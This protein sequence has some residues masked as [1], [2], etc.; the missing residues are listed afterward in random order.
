[1]LF[2][3]MCAPLLLL[4]ALLGVSTACP[5]VLEPPYLIREVG[6]KISVNCTT[7]LHQGVYWRYND[8]ETTGSNLTSHSELSIPHIDWNT[9]AMCTVKVNDTY[10]CSEYLQLTVYNVI[11]NKD[12]KIQENY[13]HTFICDIPDVATVENFT[14]TWFKDGQI[15]EPESSTKDHLTW[16]ISRAH[17]GATF[18]CETW[19]HLSPSGTDHILNKTWSLSV[20]YAPKFENKTIDISYSHFSGNESITLMCDAMGN[21]PPDYTWLKNDLIIANTTYLYITQVNEKTNYSCNASNDI[22]FD[23]Q[24]FVVPEYPVKITP[25]ELVLQYG[26]PASAICTTTVAHDGMGW[27]ASLGGISRTENVTILEWTI[28]KVDQWMISARCFVN[29]NDGKQLSKILNI[30]IYKNPDKVH[31]FPDGNHQL[32]EGQ[33]HNLQCEILNVALAGKLQVNWYQDDKLLLTETFNESKAEPQNKTST[34]TLDLKKEHNKA[35]FTCETELLLG[36]Q[37]Q[38]PKVVSA[39]Y[40][41]NVQYKPI[42][43]DCVTNHA[44]KED[45]FKLDNVPCIAIGN[46]EPDTCWYYNDKPVNSTKP[47]TKKDSGTYTVEFKNSIGNTSTTVNITVEYRP[48]FLCDTHYNVTENDQF[49]S[50]CKP[51]GVPKPTSVWFKDEKQVDF[52]KLRKRSDSG[53]YVIVAT[54]KHG[55]TNYTLSINV[56]YIDAPSLSESDTREINTGENFTLNCSAN[57]NPLP[58]LHWEYPVA[59][60]VNE[61]TRERLSITEAT[62]TNAGLYICRAT[63]EVGSATKTVTLHIKGKPHIDIIVIV[64]LLFLVLVIFVSVLMYLKHKKT[65]GHYDVIGLS[66]SVPLTSRSS[67]I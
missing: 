12:Y 52:S 28:K 56:L 49:E 20:Q 40:T 31:V 6:D 29:L 41:A 36:Q 33:Q 8:N 17:D 62:S 47:L 43:Q 11:E 1:M 15:I 64:V 10:E 14:Y 32:V 54:N 65:S 26:G 60:N 42:I 39:P 3:T 16:N 37:G 9:T 50:K 23:I 59:A 61:T 38:N 34:L 18:L 5:L 7:T 57:G 55:Q 21:P 48:F 4:T 35:N 22:G 19:S 30:I 45:E 51:E 24:T 67:V 25:N 66:D 53:Q 44:G 27:E 13:E 58:K 2:Q 63:N 46:P